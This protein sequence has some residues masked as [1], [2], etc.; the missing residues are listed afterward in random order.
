MII[1]WW[2][3]SEPCAWHTVKCPITQMHT[4]SAPRRVVVL[5]QTCPVEPSAMQK[6]SVPPPS[7]L[8]ATSY[9]WLFSTRNVVTTTELNFEFNLISIVGLPQWLSGK[10]SASSAGDIGDMGPIPGSERSPGGGNGHP[11]S[12]P[13]WRI[14]W[15]EEPGGLLSTGSQSVGHDWETEHTQT[16]F[17]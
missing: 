11:L 2:L 3:H 15:T 5:D 8:V 6:D 9:M 7:N 13:A 1:A 16:Q 17:K 4:G 14:P 12:I 10:E